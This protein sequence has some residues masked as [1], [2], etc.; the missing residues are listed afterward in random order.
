[1][2][3]HILKTKSIHIAAISL[4]LFSNIEICAKIYP[5][6]PNYKTQ[7]IVVSFPKTSDISIN[8]TSGKLLA[9]GFVWNGRDSSGKCFLTLVRNEG[10]FR[11]SLITPDENYRID[12]SLDSI[13][14]ISADKNFK[15]CAG[16][17]RE[18]GLIRD[19]RSAAQS[20][21]AWRKSDGG[22]IDLMV[23]Y[24]TEVKNDIGSLSQ[25]VAE[26][27]TAVADANLC[28]RNSLVD[29]SLRLVHIAETSYVPS[30]NLDVDLDRLTEK[31]DGFLDEI[32]ILRDQYGADI[33]TLLSTDSSS[34]G[35][36]KTMTFPSINFEKSAFNVC[37]WDQI[38][39]PS[40]TLAHEIGHNL[41]CLHNREDV[42]YPQESAGYDYGGFAY[43][44]RWFEESK[45]YRTIM[46]YNDDEGSYQN[47]VPFFSNPKVSYLGVPT[48]NDGTENNAKALSLS[49]PY[50][51]NFRKAVI[52][53]F[54]PSL[55]SLEVRSGSHSSLKLRLAVE[56]E[57]DINVTLTLQGDQ[58]FQIG[59]PS[60]INFN[61]SNW[62]L[63]VPV[64]VYAKKDTSAPFTD[65]LTISAD[66]FESVEVGL[67]LI[68]ANSTENDVNYY[69]GVVVNEYGVPIQGVQFVSPENEV[70]FISDL[71][72]TFGQ[73][74]GDSNPGFLNLKKDGY[75]FE[76]SVLSL[77]EASMEVV[78]NS[79]VGTRSSIVY[80]N[81]ASTGRNDGTSWVN[82]FTNLTD[83]LNEKA[84][85]T[86]I[87]VAAG[88]YYPGKVRSS[89]FVLPGGIKVLG[90]FYGNEK[91]ST[92]RDYSQNET[93]LSGDIGVIGDSSDNSYHVIV[94]LDDAV[95]DGFIIQDGNASENFTDSRGVGAGLWAESVSFEIRNC[96]FKNHWA[97]QGGAAIW[98]S[99]SNATLTNCSFVANQAGI[100]GKGGAIRSNN[101]QLAVGA[102]NFSHNIGPYGGGALYAEGGSLNFS[103]SNFSFNRN[104]YYN[105]GGALFLEEVAGEI[106]NCIFTSN[107]T[108]ANNYGGAVKLVDS[109]PS[110]SNCLFQRNGSLKNSAGAI[111]ID[112]ESNPI[113]SNND[114]RENF[115]SSWGGA[116]YSQSLEL[117]VTGGLFLKNWAQYGG[118]IATNGTNKTIFNGIKAYA[119][120]A[121]A[122]DNSQGGFLYLGNGANANSFVNCIF[123]RN[124]SNYRHGV[125][126]ASGE[127]NFDHCTFYG[128]EAVG[129]GAVSLLFSGDSIV[130]DNSILWNNSDANGYEIS[131]NTGSV[132]LSNSL[133]DSSKSPGTSPDSNS[134]N[135]DP[136]FVDPDGGDGI[137]GT[138]DDDFSLT[139]SSPAIDAG[140]GLLNVDLVGTLRDSKPDL[141]AYEYF[142]NTKPEYL[143]ELIFDVSEGNFSIVKLLASDADGH[144]LIFAVD[145]GDDADRVTI[146]SDN[147]QLSFVTI[148][149]F[150]YPNDLDKNN[151]YEVSIDISDGFTGIQFDIT[152]VVNDLDESAPSPEESMLLINGYPLGGKWRQ[153]S[154]FGSYF[155]ESFP[156][157]YHE[158]LGWVYIVQEKT[159]QTWMWKN[160]QGWLWT[161]IDVFPFYY[162]YQFERWAYLGNGE[163]LG[164]YYIYEEP[165]GEWLLI[166]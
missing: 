25:T 29:L 54:L 98:V 75:S 40:Y 37:V 53:G 51:S 38:T 107:E 165:E 103:L 23:I 85:I 95:L 8:R 68:E 129:S 16:C 78:K 22:Q 45:G 154:W 71:N 11:G 26:I 131:V 83:A 132:V 145:G 18:N 58:N 148:P 61:S 60:N 121:N 113:L 79:F 151:R 70:L 44:K 101:S 130:I 66:S 3:N 92:D 82:A 155:S 125:F 116:V 157:V 64:V 164:R 59:S 77:N 46:S 152:V 160:G 76:P 65:S 1:M 122:S 89:S 30:G 137:E 96:E 24:P 147:G 126:S 104:S 135:D 35:L 55:F 123:S 33:V 94:A 41:G 84:P 47:S 161:D 108:D 109:S 124:K 136:L 162:Q 56:P 43:G 14:L 150:E 4:L 114:F 140:S 63:G 159:G 12:G 42:T 143:G 20:N 27:E 99:E 166:E 106:S 62:N 119:N 153:A 127:S 32:H 91:I 93:I 7:K 142:I 48:G 72:G 120:E 97:Y 115:A 17:I 80:V 73:E 141:G 110:F 50:A 69:T 102:S 144:S 13:D 57:N 36:A 15:P 88:T 81:E 146:D 19:P 39:A 100:T 118:A 105:G 5:S 6:L 21:H 158:I 117:N 138:E 111:Y 34:G 86:E 163:F 74:F 156:W 90:G 87:W 139:A 52:Q 149:D 49:V 67:D 31:N 134:F 28:F 9:D 112:N 2:K 133:F 10:D 128:N